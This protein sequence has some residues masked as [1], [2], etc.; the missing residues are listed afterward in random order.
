MEGLQHLQG[1]LS[2]LSQ[3]IDPQVAPLENQLASIPGHMQ[4]LY[5][6]L[7]RLTGAINDLGQKT[8]DK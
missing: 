3:Q 8:V 2:N 1:Q 6:V 7:G 4:A 5:S